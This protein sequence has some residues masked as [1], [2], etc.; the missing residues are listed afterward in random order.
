MSEQNQMDAITTELAEHICD[1]LCRFPREMEQEELDEH[2]DD[3]KMDQFICDIL[4][5]YNR[6]ND[7]EQTQCHKLLQ[8]IAELKEQLPQFEIGD[9][10]YIVDYDSAVIDASVVNGIVRRTDS[11]GTE[12]EHDSDLLEFHSDDVGVIVFQS[13]GEAQEA[14]KHG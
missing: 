3:C 13:Y 7:F 10:A 6:I 11:D 9:T 14:L 8:K 5:E 2:C 4:N 12:Y 1:K